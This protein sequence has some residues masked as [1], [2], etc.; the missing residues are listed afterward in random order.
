MTLLVTCV[1]THTPN[2]RTVYMKWW[3]HDWQYY[4]LMQTIS[5][6]LVRNSEL[7]SS[8]SLQTFTVFLTCSCSILHEIGTDPVQEAAQQQYNTAAVECSAYRDYD[9]PSR[10]LI[11]FVFAI[12]Q[13]AINSWFDAISFISKEPGFLKVIRLIS[14]LVVWCLNCLRENVHEK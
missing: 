9:A 10:W 1:I 7:T 6:L 8:H 4:C 14:L 2:T 13:L 12:E 3:Q 11:Q 5:S